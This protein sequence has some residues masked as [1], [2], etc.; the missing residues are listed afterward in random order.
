MNEYE[1]S[2]SAKFLV[3]K[4][5]KDFPGFKL[6]P[7]TRLLIAEEGM[8]LFEEGKQKATV[9]YEKGTIRYPAANRIPL[10][11]SSFEDP[12]HRKDKGMVEI[13]KVSV[14]K[15]KDLTDEDALAMGY[16]SIQKLKAVLKKAF[17]PIRNEEFVSL[18]YFK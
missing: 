13:T 14:K 16:Y 9:R 3:A 18:Y 10:V 17:G 6:R 2:E 5:K 15:F 7:H 4:I 11:E 12:S 8:R 1:V